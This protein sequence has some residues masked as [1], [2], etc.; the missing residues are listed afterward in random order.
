MQPDG[1]LI[2]DVADAAQVR[3][4]LRREANALRL[5]TRERRRRA[6]ERQI[7]ESHLAQ[8]AQARAELGDQIAR[9]VALAA[10]ELELRQALL[11]HRHRQAA[12][13][14]EVL[15]LPQHGAR[16]G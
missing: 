10:R 7:A 16:L 8:E 3:A 2:E 11:Q 14:G 1:R 4:E 6:V 15:A 13:G 5:A 9:D 12:E